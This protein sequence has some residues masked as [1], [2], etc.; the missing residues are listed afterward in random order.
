MTAVLY[1]Y[2]FDASIAT[3]EIEIALLLAVWGC[4]ALYG[5]PQTRLDAAHY[6]APERRFCVIDANTPVGRDFN[7]LFVGFLTRV[8][9]ADAF[10]SKR[11]VLAIA[12]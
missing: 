8:V 6:F 1:R 12:A 10:A 3:D 11:I 5:E 4:E 7:R 9:D 2:D